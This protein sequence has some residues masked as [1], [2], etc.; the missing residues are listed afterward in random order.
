MSPLSV[1]RCSWY[2]GPGAPRGGGARHRP[3]TFQTVHGQHP[4]R[5]QAFLDQEVLVSTP[6][7][8]GPS[9][10]GRSRS[11]TQPGEKAL[12][13]LY[14]LGRRVQPA[15]PAY[16]RCQT[17]TRGAAPRFGKLLPRHPRFQ[18]QEFR[19]GIRMIAFVRPAEPPVRFD[20]VLGHAFARGVNLPKTEH[21]LPVA[22]HRRRTPL[23]DGL[24]E[25]PVVPVAQPVEVVRP[26]GTRDAECYGQSQYCETH[27][28]HPR[29]DLPGTVSRRRHY[30]QRKFGRGPID[31]PVECKSRGRRDY[32]AG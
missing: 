9:P 21:R 31:G 22:V 32:R 7:R 4:C 17:S 6:C 8:L 30:I 15:G 5:R 2:C 3:Q 20:V 18:R 14:P 29:F 12:G 27:V 16:G 1:A 10:V 28:D 24:G 13:L 19:G 23:L 11:Q 26:S 25:L